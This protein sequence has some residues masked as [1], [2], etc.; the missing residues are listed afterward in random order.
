MKL[1]RDHV[2]PLSQPV[3]SFLRSAYELRFGDFVFAG[4]GRSQPMS[5][6]T[7]LK[8]LK[9]DMRRD[10]TVHGFRAAFKTWA[11]EVTSYQN[12]AVEFCLSHIPGDEAEKAYRRR[13]MLAKRKQI[14]DAWAAFC[15]KP[16]ANV[17]DINAGNRVA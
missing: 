10:A 17:I 16:P 13:S 14:M 6:M 1:D 11:A 3:M 2:V 4:R 9:E 8:L 15:L 5:D 12:Q 7:M